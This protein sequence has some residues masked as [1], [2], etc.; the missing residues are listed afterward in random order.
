MQNR[1]ANAVKYSAGAGVRPQIR[2]TARRDDDAWSLTVDDNGPGIAAPLRERVFDVM[3]RGDAGDVPG[4]G[5]GLATCR[6]IAE[7]HRGRIA[8]EDAPSGGARLRLTLPAARPRA[9]LQG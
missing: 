3:E 8:I 2:V 5:I 7:A 9:E 4:L 1:V 6:L